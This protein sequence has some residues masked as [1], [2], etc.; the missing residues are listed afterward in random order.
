MPRDNCLYRFPTLAW[1][2]GQLR[3]KGAVR[4]KD[5]WQQRNPVPWTSHMWFPILV[6]ILTVAVTVF[7]STSRSHHLTLKY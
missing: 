2:A 1:R 5:R 6:G 7:D 4:V 3:K